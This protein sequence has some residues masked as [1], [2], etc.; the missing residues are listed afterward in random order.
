MYDERDPDETPRDPDSRDVDEPAELESAPQPEGASQ[1]E[2]RVPPSEEF[3]SVPAGAP[4]E[5]YGEPDDT[6]M[7]PP[8]SEVEAY[9]AR[10]AATD[11]PDTATQ[12]HS[13]PA[14][15]VGE[16]TRCPRC[17][18]ENRP[19]LA[20]CRNCGQR[21]IAAGVAQPVERPGTS[22]GTQVCPRCGTHNRAGT[23]FCQNCGANLRAT[24]GPGYV[25]PAVEPA[26]AGTATDTAV[27]GRSVEAPRRAVLGPLVLLIGAVGL[28]TGW[29]L[30]FPY[31]F[32]SLYERAFGA[33][34]YGINFWDGY[35][36]VAPGLVPHAYFGFAAPVPV[37]VLLVVVLAVAGITSAR[38]GPLQ[39]IGLAIALVWCAAL[40]VL[41]VLV[42][43]LGGS[44]GDL[45]A[46]LRNLTPGGIILFLASLIVIIGT[47]TRFARG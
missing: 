5:P 22:D 45:T 19:G 15:G 40:V 28:M 37:L 18:T 20:F 10:E 1:P 13:V 29:L 44:S 25:P 12:A 3:E 11:E 21:L 39:R 9:A 7:E 4:A 23:A 32:G 24:A 38:P 42:E 41:F 27:T 31:G 14:T 16:S 8:P 6:P 17:G 46:M 2:D 35:S 30:P 33:G 34:G 26:E 47:L 43:M 36:D